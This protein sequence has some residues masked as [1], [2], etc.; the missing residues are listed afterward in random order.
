MKTKKIKVFL[1]GY[2]NY[3]N[4]Q[5][6]NC[7]ALAKYLDK[8]KFECAAMLFPNGNLPVD[9]DLDGVKLFCCW[10]PVRY[11][12]YVIF[13]RGIMWCDVAYLPKGEIWEFCAKCLKWLGKKSF[14]TVEGVIDGATYEG[15]LRIARSDNGIKEMYNYTTKTYSITKYMK[16]ENKR[17]LNIE[18]DGIIYLGV[19]T[20]KFVAQSRKRMEMSNVVFIGND[21]R[22]KGVDDI[23]K[24]AERLSGITFN[25]VG[26]GNGYD[27]VEEIRRLNLKNVVYH[28]ILSHVQMAE[29][30]SKM[31]LHVFPSR[32]E[33]FPKVTLET[34]AMGVPSVVYSDYGA[35]EWITTGKN[36]YVV[37]TID[38]IEAVIKHLQQHPEKLDLL[39][40]EAI[41]LAKSFDWKV[42]V[43]DW[44]KV[45][46][47]I[48]VGEQ[49]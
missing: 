6:L 19:E 30:L 29:L 34:A 42:L 40:E 18:S 14:N 43:K 4:A 5:N 37:S 26:A 8:D 15:V 38:E 16:G 32:S 2:V 47:E 10:H 21:M 22:R 9:G 17:L 1:G 48:W 24:L 49:V 39:A 11:W 7:R 23:M 13:F 36:G 41:K 31:D 44:E 45:I 27:V 3:T 12:H 46:E 25:L 33:G 28:G 20:D 35:A